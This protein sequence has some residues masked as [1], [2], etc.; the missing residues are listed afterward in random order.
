MGV[1][2]GIP[3]REARSGFDRTGAVQSK[4]N[5]IRSNVP[6]DPGR[7]ERERDRRMALVENA[8]RDRRSPAAMSDGYKK[9]VRTAM[10]AFYDGEVPP[11]PKGEVQTKANKVQAKGWASK[12]EDRARTKL[13]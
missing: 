5:S 7:L 10:R 3:G 6:F 1:K 9:L 8:Q 13:C 12:A 4:G 11:R 2:P